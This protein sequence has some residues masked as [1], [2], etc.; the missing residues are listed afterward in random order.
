MHCRAGGNERPIHVRKVCTYTA[1]SATDRSA[2][3]VP[4]RTAGASWVWRCALGRAER[5]MGAPAATPIGLG[6]GTRGVAVA[7]ARIAAG[8]WHVRCNFS[9]GTRAAPLPW[10]ECTSGNHWHGAPMPSQAPRTNASRPPLL[11]HTA[12]PEGSVSGCTADRGVPAHG[13][14]PSLPISSSPSRLFSPIMLAPVHS[15]MHSGTQ[16]HLHPAIQRT[17]RRNS[18]SQRLR[19]TK[20]A[21]MKLCEGKPVASNQDNPAC[22]P[23]LTPPWPHPSQPQPLAMSQLVHAILMAS[24]RRPLLSCWRRGWLGLRRAWVSRLAHPRNS[25]MLGHGTGCLLFLVGPLPATV[26]GHGMRGPPDPC[27]RNPPQHMR[28]AWWLRTPK[29]PREPL[30]A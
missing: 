7:S 11:F 28:L 24:H 25:T 19:Q 29:Y 16:D 1:L 4:H 30:R 8:V 18:E 26:L 5:C 15:G 6:R 21:T 13:R 9:Q 27:R 12:A 14:S 10:A 20:Q 2:V 23:P 3:P 22:T 17:V